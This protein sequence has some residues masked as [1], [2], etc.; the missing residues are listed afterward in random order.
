[1]NFQFSIFNFQKNRGLSLVELLVGI[2]IMLIFFVS[3]VSFLNVSLKVVGTSSAKVGAVALANEQMEIVRNLP[4]DSVGTE[5]G[6]PPGNILQQ[7]TSTINNIEYTTR[8]LIQYVDDPADGEGANDENGITADYK[9][10]KVEVSWVGESFTSPVV[11]I[12]DIVPKGIETI[13]GGGT[14]K[15]NVF[16]ASVSPVVSANVHIENTDTV[17]SVFIDVFSNSDGKVVFPGA[18]SS[19]SYEITVSKSGYSTTKTYS[20]SAENSDPQPPHMTILEGETTQTSF[21]IDVLSTKTVNTYEPEGEHS[22]QDLF[23]NEENISATSSVFVNGGEV[24]LEEDPTEGYNLSGYIIS[25]T[26]TPEYLKSWNEFSW[27]DSEPVD[28]EIKY[29][30]LYASSTGQAELIPDTDL[31]GNSTG[32]GVSPVDLSSLNIATYPEV[33]LKANLTTTST[34]STPVLYD[35]E[36]SWQANRI[37]LPQIP[38]SMR[39]EKIIGYDYGVPA[40]PIYKYNESLTTDNSGHLTIS[41]L[42][43][44]NYL[45]TV[46][47]SSSGYNISEVCSFQ[48]ASISPDTNVQTD[49]LLVPH[50]TNTLL[51]YVENT[52]GQFIPDASVRLYKTGYDE[53]ISSSTTCGQ[54]FFSPLS[55][56]NGYTLEVSRDGY[57]NFSQPN[58]DVDGQT[59]IKVILSP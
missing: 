42:E 19:G 10:V 46:D 35:W 9:K 20:V 2:A 17:P 6:I 30:L 16:D 23:N 21:A 58:L 1:M 39:G 22:F 7:S 41:N 26:T 31:T 56:S 14:L 13:E 34:T 52:G 37:P 8:T 24:K 48:P 38:F 59:S 33:I 5:G 29:Y 15:I 43:W 51:V 3:L 27:N 18:P 54:S 12:T 49:I 55:A 11:L 40:N 44:D 57:G 25:S 45:I 32:F 50:Q 53:T 4:Y 47:G 36:V 28:T